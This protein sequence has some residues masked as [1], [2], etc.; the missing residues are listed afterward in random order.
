MKALVY[1]GPEE[2]ALR[3]M[4]RPAIHAPT[5]AIVHI[6]KTT[7]CGTDLHILKGDMPT[8]TPPML[9]KKCFPARS[10]AV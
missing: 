5:D 8:V 1:C 4:P 7:I 9:L 2:C 6:T 10:R 3:E